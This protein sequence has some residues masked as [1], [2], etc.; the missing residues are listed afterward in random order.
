MIPKD[1]IM[2]VTPPKEERGYRSRV[3]YEL[4]SKAMTVVNPSDHITIPAIKPEPFTEDELKELLEISQIA[5]DRGIEINELINKF[6]GD[7]GDNN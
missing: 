4:Y 2:P 7:K 1:F 5:H 6:N 3:A